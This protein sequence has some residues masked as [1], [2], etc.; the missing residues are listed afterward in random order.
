MSSERPGCRGLGRRGSY[1]FVIDAFI[2]AAILIFTL[3]LLF[4]IY[5][6]REGPEQSFTFASDYLRFVGTTEARDYD[7][8]YVQ[9]LIDDGDI[10]DARATLVDQMLRFHRL[11]EDAKAREIAKRTSEVVPVTLAINLSIQDDVGNHTVYNRSI[12]V[13]EA[14]PTHQV[15]RSLEFAIVDGSLYGPVTLQMEV[16]R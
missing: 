10:V 16:W 2:G 11:G 7:D 15:A 5:L 1:F 6:N 8:A 4:S 9:Q 13:V 14:R 12:T 3:L